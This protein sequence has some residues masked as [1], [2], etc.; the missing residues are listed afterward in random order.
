[1][2]ADSVSGEDTPLL[3]KSAFLLCPC[4]TEREKERERERGEGKREK[5]KESKLVS[6]PSSSSHK[7]ASPIGLRPH[8]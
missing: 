1:M 5:E 2:P 8:L 6:L 3:Q 4:R 7:D